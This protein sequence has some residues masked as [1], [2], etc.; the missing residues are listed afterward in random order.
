MAETW[1]ADDATAIRDAIRKLATGS[2][3]V[4]VSFSESGVSRSVTYQMTQISEL[5]DLLAEINRAIG[6]GPTY[7]LGAV[8]NG[9]GGPTG[10]T[11]GTGS[12][13]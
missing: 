7:R 2:R 9:L 10:G 4:T 11:S 8:N 1:T 13:P 5:R 6:A 12:C 3:A